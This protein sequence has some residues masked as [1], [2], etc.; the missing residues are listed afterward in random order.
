[1][2]SFYEEEL[3]INN[4]EELNNLNL[5]N[6]LDNK[7]LIDMNINIKNLIEKKINYLKQIPNKLLIINPEIK[8]NINDSSNRTLLNF[9][10]MSEQN[11]QSK[12]IFKF[13]DQPIKSLP[14]K[15][16]DLKFIINDLNKSQIPIIQIEI[17]K[18]IEKNEQLKILL[19]K[20][21]LQ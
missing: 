11:E 19:E 4:E 14:N 16:K 17:E 6:N 20:K 2:K 12:F 15:F 8:K 1:M 13:Q 7:E 21:K 18:Q 3:L 9:N 10:I 5:I